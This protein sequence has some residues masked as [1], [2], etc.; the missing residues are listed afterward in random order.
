[1][2][3]ATIICLI[4]SMV[5]LTIKGYKIDLR[6]FFSIAALVLVCIGM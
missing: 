6:L 1:M 4:F 3:I 5:T 2:K